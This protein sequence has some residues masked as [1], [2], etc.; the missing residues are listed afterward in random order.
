MKATAT[1]GSLGEKLA[2]QPGSQLCRVTVPCTLDRGHCQQ[3]LLE[4][5]VAACW[6]LL[7]DQGLCWAFVSWKLLHL[8]FV[9]KFCAAVKTQK[10][11][12]GLLQQFG[13]CK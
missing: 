3:Q 2:S 7:G 6:A 5:G 11:F 1:G 12:I 4:C 9:C 8:V 10:Q 13:G